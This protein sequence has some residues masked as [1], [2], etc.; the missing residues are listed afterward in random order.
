MTTIQRTSKPL[1]LLRGLGHLCFFGGGLTYVIH[2]SLIGLLFV[3]LGLLVLG[4]AS[5]LI[6]WFHG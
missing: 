6:W 1:K 4:I 5:L 3:A 2:D